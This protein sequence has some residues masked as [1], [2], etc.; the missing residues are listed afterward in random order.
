MSGIQKLAGKFAIASVG[1][2]AAGGLFVAGARIG[3][4]VGQIQNDPMM[5][6]FFEPFRDGSPTKEDLCLLY[7]EAAMYVNGVI[8]ANLNDL[9]IVVVDSDYTDA[10]FDDCMGYD[11][12]PI[13]QQIAPPDAGQ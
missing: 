9:D 1:L 6:H 8:G 5:S 3:H 10:I 13:L 7:Q 12:H 4:E 2:I 11:D